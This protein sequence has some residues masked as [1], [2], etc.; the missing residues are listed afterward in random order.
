MRRTGE[1]DDAAHQSTGRM[2]PQNTFTSSRRAPMSKEML[3]EVC[4][5]TTATT[6]PVQIIK[7]LNIDGY[8]AAYS[9]TRRAQNG[10][11]SLMHYHFITLTFFRG[12][13]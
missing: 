9:Y 10:M 7:S 3:Y 1:Q 11:P 6:L 5:D 4:L 8:R 2:I 13:V 12:L